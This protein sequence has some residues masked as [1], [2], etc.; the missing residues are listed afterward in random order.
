MTTPVAPR[1]LTD[2]LCRHSALNAVEAE[3][4]IVEVLSFYTERRDDFIRRRHQELQSNGLA[5]ARIFQRIL[6]ELADRR[7]PSEA[8][9]ERQIR[10]VIYG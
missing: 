1:D 7:F 10:R 9:S 2:H 5:N 4:L 3:R 6:R 8:L